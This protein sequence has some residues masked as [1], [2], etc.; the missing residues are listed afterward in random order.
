[1]NISILKSI[2]KHPDAVDFEITIAI[3]DSAKSTKWETI[4]ISWAQ[5]VTAL[6]E[7]R[8]TSETFQE[9]KKFSKS[10][11]AKCKDVGAFLGGGLS[12]P[13][14]LK[15]AV[16]GRSAIT[17]DFDGKNGSGMSFSLGELI[18]L[19]QERF[20]FEAAFYTTHSHHKDAPRVRLIIPLAQELDPRQ[21]EPAARAIAAELGLNEV[22]P[23]SF[24]VAQCMFLPS[25]SKDGE[26]RFYHNQGKL[27]D[28]A[29]LLNTYE[30]WA[31]QSEWPRADRETKKAAKEPPRALDWNDTIYSETRI[32]ETGMIPHEQAIRAVRKWEERERG[33]LED[34]QHFVAAMMIIAKSVQL[35]EISTETGRECVALLAGDREDWRQGNMEKFEKEL[36]NQ[37]IRTDKTFRMKFMYEVANETDSVDFTEVGAK[38]FKRNS[39]SASELRKIEF[40]PLTFFVDDLITP[41]LTVLAAPPKSG[42]S[43]LILSM[44]MSISSGT[45]FLGRKTAQ[46]PSLFLALEDSERRIGARMEKIDPT[47]DY[48]LLEIQTEAVPM[49]NIPGRSGNLKAIKT[50]ENDFLAFLDEYHKLGFRVFVVDVFQ[51]IRPGGTNPNQ[52]EGDY[53]EVAPLQKWAKEKD[54]A[55]ILIHHFKKGSQGFDPVERVG[56]ST[57]ITGSADT[58]ITIEKE[59]RDSAISTFMVTGRDVSMQTFN[60]SFTDGK[61][62]ISDIAESTRKLKEFEREQYEKDPLV[63]TIKHLLTKNSEI[64]ITAEDLQKEMNEYCGYDALGRS[65]NKAAISKISL[66]LMLNDKIT[67]EYKQSGMRWHI[68]QH[69]DRMVFPGY[70]QAEFELPSISSD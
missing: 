44:L 6:K 36:D 62:A 50:W 13:R 40:P 58:I 11:Q 60:A 15:T 33:N 57:G 38:E 52:Y 34:Y 61:W 21:Y 54:S 10:E 35:N 9:Y 29:D 22:D 23:A 43:W 28:P 20:N 24:S 68:F 17:L 18:E 45:P 19:Y 32:N 46:A 3:G 59:M 12:S 47:Y 49:I 14:R 70:E 51:K 7:T 42:K 67:Y 41:G 37:D 39:I 5:L 30:D 1:M 25:S 4:S 69:K 53:K 31:D 48:P 65:V 26:F 63:R 56:G 2:E 27:L 64:K 16:T 55:L 66:Q 8:A